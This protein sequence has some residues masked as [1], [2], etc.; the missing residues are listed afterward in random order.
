MD[1]KIYNKLIQTYCSS[2]NYIK[3]TPVCDGCIFAVNDI[4]AVVKSEENYTFLIEWHKMHEPK[5]YKEYFNNK[6]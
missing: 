6:E 3:D 2:F 4:C 5:L 1:L